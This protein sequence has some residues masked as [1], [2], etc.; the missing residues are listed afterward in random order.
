M[1]TLLPTPLTSDAKS[2]SSA[3]M[4]RR[5]PQLRA[6][7]ALLPTPACNDMGENKTIEWWDEWAPRQVSST[8]AA[9]PHGKSLSIE[10]RKH[11][12]DWGQYAKAIARWE[13]I[14]GTPAPEST[15]PST[16]GGKR[17]LS[18]EFAEWLM[19]LE[20]GWV[21]GNDISRRAMLKALGN[22]VVPQQAIAALI[23]MLSFIELGHV[24]LRFV[25][26]EEAHADS[27]QGVRPER[28][29]LPAAA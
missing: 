5:S 18:A 7:E 21:T 4:D 26:G 8:G 14:F 10:A 2:A 9:A 3:D 12:T 29:V 22:G 1:L 24:P 13:A 16:T 6:V 19:G 28:E 11:E 20:A 25:L 15:V 17:Q 23:E 27:T